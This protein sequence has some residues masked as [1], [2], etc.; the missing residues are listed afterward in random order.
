GVVII[1]GSFHPQVLGA[2]LAE[3]QRA[4]DHYSWEGVS[5][6][7]VLPGTIGSDARAIGGALLP[8]YSNFGPDRDLF[9]KLSA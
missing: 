9:L 6:P 2:L 8:L 3:I 7:E 5:R 1:D 4:L